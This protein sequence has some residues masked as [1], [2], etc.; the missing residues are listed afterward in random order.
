[1]SV[2]F[3]SEDSL[4]KLAASF[5]RAALLTALLPK[6]L[7]YPVLGECSVLVHR[8]IRWEIPRLCRGGSKSSTDPGVHRI[9][10]EYV[11]S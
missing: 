8:L 2:G 6:S 5:S 10:I 11:W 1:M 4:T 7:D 3:R 9:D